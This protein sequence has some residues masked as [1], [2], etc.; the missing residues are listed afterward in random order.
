[1]DSPDQGAFGIPVTSVTRSGS[2]L[3]LELK[4]IGGA[5]EGK[6]ST[7][8]KTIEGTC[9]RGAGSLPLTLKRD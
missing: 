8:L 2:S 9:T 1:M 7:D 4:Q 6:I 3:K 5:F